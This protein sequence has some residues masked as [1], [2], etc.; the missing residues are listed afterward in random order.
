MRVR[1]SGFVHHCRGDRGDRRKR[2]P[3]GGLEI[4]ANAYAEP[5]RTLPRRARPDC[6]RN[7]IPG[8]RKVAEGMARPILELASPFVA[9]QSCGAGGSLRLPRRRTTREAPN[10]SATKALAASRTG[11]PSMVTARSAGG[12]VRLR[13]HLGHRADLWQSGHA[14]QTLR[15]IEASARGLNRAVVDVGGTRGKIACDD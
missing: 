8:D 14:T 1:A 4:C 13:A 5:L 6:P 10:R 9:R 7:L 3:H 2:G 11:E 12:P 15:S